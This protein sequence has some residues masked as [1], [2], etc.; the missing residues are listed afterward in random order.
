M[1]LKYVG[2]M[3]LV[4]KVGVGFDHTKP[5]KYIYL[6]A[7]LE[8]LEALSYGAT[9]STQHLYKAQYKEIQP[10]QLLEGLK[11][12]IKNLDEVYA[13][14]EEKTRKFIE[15]YKQRV[16]HNTQLSED[17]KV[18]WLKNI[19]LM[20]DYYLQYVTNE[21]VYE[22][23]LQALADAIKEAKVQ[24]IR[25]P[26]FRNYGFVLKDLQ[27]VLQTQKAPIDAEFEIRSEG[28]D[29]VGVMKIRHY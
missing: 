18:A 13:Q 4:S 6:H 27:N 20:S 15:Q 14:R 7:I 23:A 16:E 11:K 21:T 5:D 3:P 28:D 17:E 26:I 22:A 1:E 12:Y 29:L 2:D 10:R 9:E 24:E 19:D 25:V 8:L